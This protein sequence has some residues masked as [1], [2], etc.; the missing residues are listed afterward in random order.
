M[1]RKAVNRDKYTGDMDSGY[2]EMTDS[3]SHNH[4][5]GHTHGRAQGDERHKHGHTHDHAHNTTYSKQSS[6]NSSNLSFV[7]DTSPVLRADIDATS[8]GDG[9]NP[10]AYRSPAYGDP[11]PNQSRQQA[12]QKSPA[13]GLPSQQQSSVHVSVEPTSSLRSAVEIDPKSAIDPNTIWLG[14]VLGKGAEGVVRQQSLD[15]I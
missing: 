7:V 5:H 14:T 15:L 6:A 8:T 12:R 4:T 9:F 11:T 10:N 13:S 3:R 2:L 1:N